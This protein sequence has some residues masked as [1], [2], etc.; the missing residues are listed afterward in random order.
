MEMKAFNDRCQALETHMVDLG[1][2]T[3]EVRS[4]LRFC[5]FEAAIQIKAS[6][7]DGPQAKILQ[8]ELFKNDDPEALLARAEQWVSEQAPPASLREDNF[9]STLAY[10]VEEGRALGTPILP[11]LEATLKRLSTNIL[12]HVPS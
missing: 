8:S 10:L 5:G 11:D 6:Y 1:F 3:P 9:R 7:S 4:Y 2:V 12:E